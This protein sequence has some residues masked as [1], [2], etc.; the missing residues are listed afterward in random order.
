MFIAYFTAQ[1][2]TSAM[3]LSIVRIRFY[4]FV[5]EHESSWKV[6][7]STNNIERLIPAGFWDHSPE[8]AL[9]EADLTE[10]EEKLEG[11]EIKQMLIRQNR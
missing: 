6:S 9:K 4:R 2:A 5:T 8:A 10:T 7:E 11:S 1:A 3:S